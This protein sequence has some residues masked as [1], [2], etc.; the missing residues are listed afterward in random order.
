M[1]KP[2]DMGVTE[3]LKP[4]GTPVGTQVLKIHGICA[5]SPMMEKDD[6]DEI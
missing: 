4:I 3:A 1:Y 6:S 2:Y 5:G